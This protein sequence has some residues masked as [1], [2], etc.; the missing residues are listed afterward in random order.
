MFYGD[1]PGYYCPFDDDVR[2]SENCVHQLICKYEEY[3]RK[4]IVSFHGERYPTKDGEILACYGGSKISLFRREVWHGDEFCHAIGGCCTAMRPSDFSFGKELFL[5]EPKNLGDDEIMALWAQKNEVPLIAVDNT[6]CLL[7]A[8]EY[9]RKV[10]LYYTHKRE[11]HRY[12]VLK[13]YR[14]WHLVTCVPHKVSN[15]SK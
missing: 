12:N 8:Q 4:A 7:Y 2:Y 13:S 11:N 15:E 5:S 9:D 10:G 1:F 3:G 6:H 14:N